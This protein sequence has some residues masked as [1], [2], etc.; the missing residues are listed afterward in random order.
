M[1]AGVKIHCPFGFL[2]GVELDNRLT[3]LIHDE[4]RTT[5][6]CSIAK[7]PLNWTCCKFVAH[8][9]VQQVYNKLQ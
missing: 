8:R 1:T 6:I 5:L 2:I 4:F 3:H 9:A 7:T